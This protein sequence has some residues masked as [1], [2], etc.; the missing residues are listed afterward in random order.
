MANK[1][2]DEFDLS[3]KVAAITG[4]AGELCGAMSSA[5][6]SLGVKVALL[7]IDFE[8]AEIKAEGICRDGGKAIAVQCDVLDKESLVRASE[9]I[10]DEWR[11][12]NLLINGAGGNHPMG[13]TD[14][15]FFE[16]GDLD[17]DQVKSFFDL[18]LE[19]FNKVLDLNFVGTFLPTQ[20][21][22]RK[23]AEEGQGAILNIS[24]M[25]YYSPLTKI[26][27]YAAAKAAVSNLTQWLAIHFAHVGIRV[28]AIAPG[29]LMT[30]QLK[31]LH[32]NQETG[33]YTPRAKKVI[34]HTP[35][36]RYG[37]PEELIGTVI[38]LLSEASRFVTGVTVPI[39]G[40]FSSYSI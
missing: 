12:P 21:F 14:K 32:I 18:P 16:L 30:E 24:S 28:N 22:S 38:W 33:E 7:D 9:R 5:L 35:A 26:P 39:D 15:E 2:M 4:A 10:A 19:G 36:G 1:Y 8:K 20:V 29:F 6:G 34:G 31:F 27:A 3:G 37:E 40:G 17:D 13:T 25:N 11:A 23:M